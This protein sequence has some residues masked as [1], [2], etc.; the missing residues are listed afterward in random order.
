MSVVFLSNN[1]THHQ[2]PLSDALWSL[3]EGNYTFVETSEK[4]RERQRRGIRYSEKPYV[5]NYWEN[6]ARVK[7]LIK[8]ADVVISGSA[9]EFLVRERVRTGQL[10]F[11]YSE[12]PLKK[13]L[14]VW[15][16]PVRFLR[17]HLRNPFGKPIY[18]LCASAYTAPDYRKFGLF[19]NKTYKWG[20]FPETKRY[21]DPL[22]M[23]AAKDPAEIL[24][25]GRFLELKHP[26]DVLAVARILKAEG[27]SFRVKF[28]GSGVLEEKLKQLTREYDLED[29][30]S[31]LGQMTPEQVRTHMEKAGIYL[32]TSDRQEGW[33][34]VLNESMNSGCAVIAGHAAGSV[35]YLM[36]DGKNGL[37]YASGNVQALCDKVRYLLERPDEQKRLGAAAYRTITET[38]NAELAAERFAILVRQLLSKDQTAAQFKSGPCSKTD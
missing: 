8:E 20:Y 27:H 30:V 4:A 18:L 15:R 5:L 34:A 1:F 37:I 23:I 24:W 38:W 19:K 2:V 25:C 29:C 7:N 16:Y 22:G 12:R 21:E 10:L 17:W 11:R 33:G 6:E 26:E 32:F 3:T 28:I 31:F 36:E 13:G 35:P 9:P 14:E